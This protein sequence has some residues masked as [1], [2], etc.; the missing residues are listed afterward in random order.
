MRS[1]LKAWCGYAAGAFATFA[2]TGCFLFYSRSGTHV[3]APPTPEPLV[4]VNS[5]WDD[6][7]VAQPAN[8]ARFL[9]ATNQGSEGKHFDIWS[10]QVSWEQHPR[11][12]RA[13]GP[14]APSL[15]SDADERGPLYIEEKS[16]EE[17][18]RNIFVL[19]SNRSGGK[20]GLDLYWTA[21]CA[22]WSESCDG[23]LQPLDALNSPANDAYLSQLFAPR[24]ALFASDRAGN[25]Y[26][27]HEATWPPTTPM[28]DPPTNIRVVP[29]LSSAEDDNAPYVVTLEDKGIE[30]VFAS[31]RPGGMG[32]HDLWCSHFDGKTWQRPRHLGAKINSASDEFRPIV[33]EISEAQ[34]LVWSSNRPGGQGGYDLYA[35][36]YPG[37]E[38]K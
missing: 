12:L 9:F 11:A 4:G 3:T 37:C 18:W 23:P 24:R 5:P 20:G 35:I 38:A 7:N 14:F 27:I 6:F 21:G 29:E 15:M 26:D 33:F 31:K 28:T 30:L 1:N 22:P 8:W 2:L 13:P 32:E 19:T 10:T 17:Q 34:F 36:Q 16:S 25:G